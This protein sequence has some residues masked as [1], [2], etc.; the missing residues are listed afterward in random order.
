MLFQGQVFVQNFARVTRL[1]HKGQLATDVN[2]RQVLI[3]G[4]AIRRSAV[5]VNPQKE[6]AE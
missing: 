1:M 4:P 2:L 3:D 5:R 6:R